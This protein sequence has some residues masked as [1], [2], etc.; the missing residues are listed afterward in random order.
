MIGLYVIVMRS[1]IIAVRQGKAAVA[2]E[3]GNMCYIKDEGYQVGQIIE[4]RDDLM[5]N[6]TYYGRDKNVSHNSGV[7]RVIAKNSAGLAAA[8]CL[9]A[10]TGGV[11]SYAAPVKTVTD[12]ENPDI[13]YSVNM[14]NHVIGVSATEADNEAIIGDIYKDIRWKKVDD[15]MEIIHKKMKEADNIAS[16]KDELVP[17]E[18]EGNTQRQEKSNDGTN[19][20]NSGP[21][22]ED[23]NAPQMNG[24]NAEAGQNN[25]ELS[26]EKR[27]RG[28]EQPPSGQPQGGEQPPSE[29]P[30]GGEQPPSGQPQGGEQPPS[31]QLQEGEQ[32][33]SD[34]PQGEQPQGG[35]QPPS[36][37]SQGE[38]PQGGHPQDEQLDGE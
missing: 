25:N 9:A 28:G 33:P 26:E 27:P 23:N 29:Q 8:L 24:S 6:H 18:P 1:V 34:G 20:L 5:R 14:Y 35:G 22:E 21:I 37:G 12:S 7:I 32:P 3:D 38:Q 17:K 19:Q 15:A 11:Y 13:E 10:L 30:Q 4:V 31:E 16:E 2:G 36:D